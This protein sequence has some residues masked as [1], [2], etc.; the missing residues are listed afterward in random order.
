MS[1]NSKVSTTDRKNSPTEKIVLT[2]L[3]VPL[4]PTLPTHHDKNFINSKSDGENISTSSN[5]SSNTSSIA[6]GST[7]SSRIEGQG[8]FT[9]FDGHAG[10]QAA[11][12]CGN[13]FHETF[14]EVLR[15]KPN[16]PI[17]EIFHLAFLRADKQLNQNAGKHSGCT[18][19]S[20]F[21]RLE[22]ITD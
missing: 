19:I 16:D 8:F 11:E 20:A 9:I 15:E 6:S 12:W 18:A 22:K 21:L 10:K 1:S 13:H 14:L 2:N 7:P 4:T 17:P 5:T 3:P